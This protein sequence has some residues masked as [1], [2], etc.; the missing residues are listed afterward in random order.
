LR[1]EEL[2]LEKRLNILVLM[3]LQMTT[4]GEVSKVNKST[5]RT[6]RMSLIHSIDLIERIKLK[7]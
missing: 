6:L 4:F 7:R 5:K 3:T 2:D 1:T